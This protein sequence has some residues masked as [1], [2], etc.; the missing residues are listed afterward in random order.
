M[1][2]ISDMVK[3]TISIR[4]ETA[5]NYYFAK[6]TKNRR[7]KVFFDGEKFSTKTG[8]RKLL[9]QIFH[10]ET[11]RFAHEEL[12]GGQGAFGETFTAKSFVSEG[13][14]VGGRKGRDAVDA[15]NF[16]FSGDFDG[17]DIRENSHG[18]RS[19]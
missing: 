7:Q 5:L 18:V 4:T 16:A 9:Q 3:K 8:Y 13:D 19:L 12:G 2:S 14:A 17:E 11:S 6:V 1:K 10:G 15:E